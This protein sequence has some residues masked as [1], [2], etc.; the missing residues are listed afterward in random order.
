VWIFVFLLPAVSKDSLSVLLAGNCSLFSH[1]FKSI[2]Y[3]YFYFYCLLL[4]NKMRFDSVRHFTHTKEKDRP[5][6]KEFV[7]L[8]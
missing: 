3:Y 7:S 4:L 2:F 8:R 6:L 5:R 1:C